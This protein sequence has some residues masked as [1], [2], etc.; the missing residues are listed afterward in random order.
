MTEDYT[1]NKELFEH[2]GCV[3]LLT[4]TRSI[5]SV[6][7]YSGAV[8]VADDKYVT[9]WNEDRDEVLRRVRSNAEAAEKWLEMKAAIKKE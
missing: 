5:S 6:P 3:C 9:G 7:L 8:F 2:A 4:T 1:E